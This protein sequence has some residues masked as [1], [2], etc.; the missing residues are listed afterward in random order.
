M[1][2]RDAI[3]TLATGLHQ[4][5]EEEKLSVDGVHLRETMQRQGLPNGITGNITFQSGNNNRDYTQMSYA[6]SNFQSGQFV[7]LGSIS[8][9]DESFLPCVPSDRIRCASVPVFKGLCEASIGAHACN[10]ADVQYFCCCA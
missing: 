5:M 4:V 7:R 8:L 9:P 10:R 1:F 2:L 3:F 6:I